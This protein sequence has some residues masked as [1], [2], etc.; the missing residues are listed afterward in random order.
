MDNY[1]IRIVK[2]PP[3]VGGIT[4]PDENGDYNIYINSRL[5]D[6]KMVEVYDHE[7]YHI[8]HGHF[9]D[10]TKTV[11]EK[12]AEANANAKKAEKRYMECV[13]VYWADE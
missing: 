13:S 12:E 4:I 9:S 7:V 8:E 1:I 11:A 5:S 2:L 6:A 3:H 10:D